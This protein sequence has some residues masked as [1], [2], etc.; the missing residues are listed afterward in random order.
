LTTSLKIGIFTGL[1]LPFEEEAGC[2][3]SPSGFGHFDEE[4]SGMENLPTYRMAG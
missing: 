3:V 1:P 2:F 4:R